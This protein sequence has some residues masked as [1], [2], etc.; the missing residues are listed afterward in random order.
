MYDSI[1]N[2]KKEDGTMLCDNFIRAPKR[3][4][5]PSYYD[6]V[7]NPIDLLRVQQKL[8]T[9]SYEDVDELTADMDLLIK[10]SKAFYRPDSTEYQDACLLWETYVANKGRMLESMISD[11]EPIIKLKKIGRPRKSANNLDN[12]DASETSS[13]ATDDDMDAYE[14]LFASVMNATDD[15]N[16]PLNLMFQLLPSRKQYPDY[17]D[18]IEHPIDLKFIATKIQTNAYISLTEME[19]DLLQ[20]TKNACTFNEPGSQIYK[21]A[22]TLKKIFVAR[23]LEIESGRFKPK[24]AKTRK[25]AQSLSAVVAALKEPIEESD[26]EID[27]NMENE[28]DGPLWQ[29]FDQLYNAPN[30]SGN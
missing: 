13:K 9:D 27:D 24:E 12:D 6:V 18:I 5:E 16:R 26:D 14:E 23:K 22:K 17:Y 4:Q 2:V 19:K 7:E 11:D 21:D 1:R 3:R 20:M 10:N 30:A 15:S 8:K 25:R 28:V 29:L